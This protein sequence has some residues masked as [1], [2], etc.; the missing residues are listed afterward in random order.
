M[1]G[2]CYEANGTRTGRPVLRRQ[3]GKLNSSFQAVA[4]EVALGLGTTS[5]TFTSAFALGKNTA[6]NLPFLGPKKLIYA[7]GKSSAT[8]STV[9]FEDWET[10]GLARNVNFL[11]P[12]GDLLNAAAEGYIDD[13]QFLAPTGSLD[14]QV[15]YLTITDGTVVPFAATAVLLNP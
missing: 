2:A 14:L 13:F 12:N 11:W 9:E 5:N 1:T 7:D 3:A 8:A 10:V 15:L 4:D 6:S